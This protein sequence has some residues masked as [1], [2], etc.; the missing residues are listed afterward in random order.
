MTDHC[1]S[2]EIDV[3][4]NISFKSS[5]INNGSVTQFS[6]IFLYRIKDFLCN[7]WNLILIKYFIYRI[8]KEHLTTN[9][10][11]LSFSVTQ[12]WSPNEQLRNLKVL[13]YRH[14]KTITP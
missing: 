3:H 13:P 4:S 10:S 11:L 2:N 9:Q 8:I 1:Y 7:D 6:V 12:K 14:P 5:R